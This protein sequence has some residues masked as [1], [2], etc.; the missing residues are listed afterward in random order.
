MT[1]LIVVSCALWIASL[2][3]AVPQ[4]AAPQAAAPAAAASIATS[5]R[6]AVDKYCVTCH[7]QRLKTGNLTLDSADLNNV[8]AHADVWEKVIRKV[9]AGMRQSRAAT[10]WSSCSHHAARRST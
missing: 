4:A 8:A 3:I 6:A 1:R 7:N 9:E 2:S 5:D 10:M